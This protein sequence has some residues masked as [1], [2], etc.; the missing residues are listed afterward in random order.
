MA[1]RWDFVPEWEVGL[2]GWSKDFA[3]GSTHTDGS[4]YILE[5]VHEGNEARVVNVDPLRK[6]SVTRIE[7]QQRV[8]AYE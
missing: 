7:G 1:D 4:E 3:L 6:V 5:F 2:A 8:G